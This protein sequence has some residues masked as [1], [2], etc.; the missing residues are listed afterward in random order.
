MDNINYGFPEQTI[1][2]KRKTDKWRKDCIDWGD[3]RS[4]F[5]YGPVMSTVN[6]MKKNYDLVNGIIHKEDILPLINPDNLEGNMYPENIKHHPIIN[7]KLRALQGE[8]TGRVFDHRVIITNPNSLSELEQLKKQEIYARLYQM[9]MDT[10]L[11][12][13]QAMAELEKMDYYFTYEWQDFR[14]IRA[15]EVLNHY[16]LEQDF[17]T[18]FNDGFLD[19]SIAAAEIY[20]TTIYCGE[21]YLYKL[22]PLNVRVFQ[23]GNSNRVEDADMIVIEEYWQA[24]RIIDTYK[25]Y[26]TDEQTKKIKK[27]AFGQ[28]DT[29]LDNQRFVDAHNAITGQIIESVLMETRES[30]DYFMDSSIQT[31]NLAYDLAGNVKVLRVYWKS[32]RK[33]RKVKS[34]DINTGEEV[35][36]FRPEQYKLNEDLG[37]TEE[38]FWVNEAWEGTKI[39]DDI[40]VCMRPMPTQYNRLGDPS[41]CHFGIIGNIYSINNAQ[42]YSL[43]DMAKNY[44]LLYDVIWD[45]VTKTLAEDLGK[46][47]NF[48]LAKMPDKWSLEEVLYHAKTSHLLVND[49]FNVGQEG[50]A[51]GILAGSMNNNTSPIVDASLGGIIDQLI[52]IMEFCKMEM[53]EVMGITKQ[54]EGQIANRETVGGVERSVLQSSYITEWIFFKHENLK[55][56]V[57]E[58]FIEQCKTAFRGR[59]I[60]FQYILSDGSRKVM[61]FDGDEFC[62]CD[63]GLV[64]DNSKASQELNQKLDRLAEFALQGQMSSLATIM[65]LYS[66]CSIAEKQRL[67]EREERKRLEMA[68]QQQQMAMQQQ[69][70]QAEMAMQQKQMEMQQEDMLNQRDNETKVI[71]A[72]LQSLSKMESSEDVY[73]QKDREK[74]L[75]AM[76]EFDAKL[77]LDTQR[78]QLDEKKA[79]DDKELRNKQ[80]DIQKSK[81]N[82]TNQK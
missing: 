66:S 39:G 58:A 15:N 29:S 16:W 7:S 28:G 74:L 34:F 24:G 38:V 9:I 44:N 48:D 14:E 26:L 81:A 23:R 6:N 1:S 10:S 68:Q 65:R 4:Y 8:E 5:N 17:P 37:E 19:A 67:V 13:E 80:L 82:T 35:I 60:K 22:D 45:K 72:K 25:E 3:N 59:N 40:Y 46:L 18:T 49:S 70:Q 42:P 73:S 27:M 57:C 31:E 79:R 11:S 69:Q 55:K 2:Y 36:T 21:P 53:G 41:R 32:C 43:V 47:V 63:Y 52:N 75:E 20:Q 77:K 62:E 56:R 71:I 61:E 64:V 30:T 33:I 76:R 51:K 78:L 54:R 12:E 50:A